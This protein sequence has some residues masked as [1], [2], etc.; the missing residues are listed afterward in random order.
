MFSRPFLQAFL[1]FER[2]TRM[3]I[4]HVVVLLKK[5]NSRVV[6]TSSVAFCV[7]HVWG[8]RV[9]ITFHEK[10]FFNFICQKDNVFTFHTAYHNFLVFFALND[11]EMCKINKEESNTFFHRSFFCCKKIV[12]WL[13]CNVHEARLIWKLHDV[14]RKEARAKKTNW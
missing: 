1:R 9:P 13:T 5:P 8:Y 11:E 7:R 3:Y 10:C 2:I 4:V 14:E 6:N 12:Y